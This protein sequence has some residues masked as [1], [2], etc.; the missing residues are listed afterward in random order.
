MENYITTFWP[1][2]NMI[3]YLLIS[4]IVRDLTNTDKIP[5]LSKLLQKKKNF[6]KQH[7]NNILTLAS[8]AVSF[9]DNDLSTKY[10]FL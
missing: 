6:T 4:I 8:H 3:E 10:L 7:L 5:S 2:P 9:L 1:L